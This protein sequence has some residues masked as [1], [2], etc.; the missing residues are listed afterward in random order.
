MPVDNY[1]STEFGYDKTQYIVIQFL[2]SHKINENP[3]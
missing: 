1:L 3:N 2:N